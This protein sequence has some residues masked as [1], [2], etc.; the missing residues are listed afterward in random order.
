M[1]PGSMSAAY[2]KRVP[3]FV[4]SDVPTPELETEL[5]GQRAHLRALRASVPLTAAYH[6]TAARI[7]TLEAEL[8]RRGV[9][10]SKVGDDA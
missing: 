1:L 2:G 4:Y 10:P 9:D 5:L 3:L 7:R 8:T 6:V